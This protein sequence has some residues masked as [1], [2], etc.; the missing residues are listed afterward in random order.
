MSAKKTQKNKQ[1]IACFEPQMQT[2]NITNKR[3]N[4]LGQEI[5]LTA[6]YFNLIKGNHITKNLL[7][8]KTKHYW[9]KYLWK[10]TEGVP[11]LITRIVNVC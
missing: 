1:L 4:D 8:E 3:F 6:A 11:G 5:L 9:L 7:V 10:L 2:K